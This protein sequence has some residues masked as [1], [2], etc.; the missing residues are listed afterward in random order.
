M[1]F[2]QSLESYGQKEMARRDKSQ[3]AKQDIRGSSS[4]AKSQAD[5]LSAGLE[6]NE[7]DVVDG[8]VDVVRRTRI[9][10]TVGPAG[11][12]APVRRDRV[13]EVPEDAGQLVRIGRL[14]RA[15][16]GEIGPV[17]RHR[18]GAA[19]SRDDHARARTVARVF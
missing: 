10:P 3:R 16:A 8:E 13:V 7:G 6:R 19:V 12:G 18:P 11:V 2:G 1:E 4:A 15:A 17:Q 14:I 5:W 9:G